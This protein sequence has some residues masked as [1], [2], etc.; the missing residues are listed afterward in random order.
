MFFTGLVKR[1][2]FNGQ[3]GVVQA[4]DDEAQR[5]EVQ[6]KLVSRTWDDEAQRYEV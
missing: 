5:Y 4:W 3:C 1:P 6:V 2:A